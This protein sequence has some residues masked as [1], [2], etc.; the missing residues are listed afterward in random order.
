VRQE[1]LSSSED[2]VYIDI[3]YDENRNKANIFE[4]R[5]WFLGKLF[6]PSI[7]PFL[8]A[9]GKRVILNKYSF[10][11]RN[12]V[13]STSIKEVKEFCEFR[14][15]DVLL[16]INYDPVL[17]LETTDAVPTG[18]RPEEKIPILFKSSELKIPCIVYL[19]LVRVRPPPHNSNAF[20][21]PRVCSFATDLAQKRKV[22]THV[23]FS[24]SYTSYLGDRLKEG[25][26][27]LIKGL[28]KPITFLQDY[29]VK[30]VTLFFGGKPL[31]FSDM[32]LELVEIAKK[33]CEW[34]QGYIR[35]RKIVA[36]S[37]VIFR[38]DPDRSWSERGTGCFGAIEH[39]IEV[40]TSEGKLEVCFPNLG[41][42]F[43][44]FR[45][46]R[47]GKRMSLLTKF[48]DV[49]KFQNDLSKDEIRAIE[50]LLREHHKGKRRRGVLFLKNNVPDRLRNSVVVFSNPEDWFAGIPNELRKV[51]SGSKVIL[52]RLVK[53][54]WFFKQKNWGAFISRFGNVLYQEDLTMDEFKIL[55]QHFK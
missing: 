1:R 33:Y 32:D 55:E 11:D 48:A 17:V 29:V 21:N 37:N 15:P 44:F 3:W 26:E 14:A 53:D 49:I 2:F 20:C 31:E 24:E 18:N 41:E 50:Q 38:H 8:E 34:R 25:E 46:R 43:W 9:Q 6:Y 40:K 45:E 7:K 42:N 19:P 27:D 12:A 35:G 54:F 22:P 10:K 5:D 23:V 47:G 28:I 16:L 30:R 13:R 51:P 36:G 4:D 39:A 52:P